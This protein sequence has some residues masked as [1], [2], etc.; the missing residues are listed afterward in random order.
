MAEEI[1]DRIRRLIIDG[2]LPAGA[3]LPAERQLAARFGVSRGWSATRCACSRPSASPQT[4]HGQ[5]TFPHEL[6]VDRLVAPLTSILT[7]SPRPAR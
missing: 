1:A 2:T 3:P 6:D 5:G 7:L 4:R